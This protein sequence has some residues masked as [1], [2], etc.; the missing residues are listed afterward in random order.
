MDGEAEQIAPGSDGLVFLPY[1]SG[2]RSPIWD[3][4]AKGVYYGLDYTKRRAH[5]IRASM[6]GVAYSLMHNLDAAREAGVDVDV[7]HAV[8]GGAKSALW[9]GMKA[10]VTGKEIVMMQADAATSIGTIILAGVGV[11]IYKDFEEAVNVFVKSGRR[12]SPNDDNRAVYRKGYETYRRLY[13]EL[14][15]L[16]AGQ[17]A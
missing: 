12:L 14:K 1:M 13:N 15:E 8:G 4:K 9:C 3:D 10:D 6:E 11:G 17:E 7:L 16:M 2:E 5:F